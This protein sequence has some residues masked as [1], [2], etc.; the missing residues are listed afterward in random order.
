MFLAF[1]SA[2]DADQLQ[3]FDLLLG[4]LLRRLADG[5]GAAGADGADGA[6]ARSHGRTWMAL[7]LGM[8]YRN[9]QVIMIYR[10]FQ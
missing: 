2:G 4:L 3:H 6:Q 5:P 1:R 10:N 7:D 8:I 9:I